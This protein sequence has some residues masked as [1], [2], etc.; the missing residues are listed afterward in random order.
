MPVTELAG[1][2]D[3]VRFI[4]HFDVLGPHRRSLSYYYLD[5]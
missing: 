4:I 2:I 3:K 1:F 5:W